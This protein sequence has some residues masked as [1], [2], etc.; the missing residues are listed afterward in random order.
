MSAPRPVFIIGSSRSGTGLTTRLLAANG[1]FAGRDRTPNEES[2]F[3]QQLTRWVFLNGG[4]TL[5]TPE[6]LD[7]LLEDDLV[8]DVIAEV[9]RHRVES[10]RAVQFFGPRALHRPRVWVVKDPRLTFA[11]PL[12]LRAYPGARVVHVLRHGIDV[13]ASL[14]A[15]R[16][17]VEDKWRAAM[18]TEPELAAAVGAHGHFLR[19]QRTVANVR[20]AGYRGAFDHWTRYVDRAE[21]HV[22]A[23]GPRVITVWFED[24]AEP[25][26]AD[27]L[28]QFLRHPITDLSM[29]RGER[30]FAYRSRPELLE[31]ADLWASDLARFGYTAREEAVA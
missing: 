11:L 10:W 31:L 14:V 21:A 17:R 20:M 8:C 18:R 3:F 15:R 12:W 6:A 2:R 26:T 13:A 25:W 23:L 29:V 7:R 9:L 27:R 19:E 4:G 28:E 30:Q 1:L 5:E 16:Q 24:L 22:R